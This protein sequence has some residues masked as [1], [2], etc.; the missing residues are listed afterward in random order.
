LIT[1]RIRPLNGTSCR[2]HPENQGNN[3][4]ESFGWKKMRKLESGAAKIL[5]LQ[6]IDMVMGQSKDFAAQISNSLSKGVVD[7]Q[8][9]IHEEITMLGLFL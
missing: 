5:A 9:R 4:P 2:F 6:K 7:R 8:N 3:R 1:Q